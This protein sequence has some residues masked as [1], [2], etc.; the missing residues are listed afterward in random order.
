MR[1]YYEVFFPYTIL[2]EDVAEF[3]ENNKDLSIQNTGRN[4]E[5]IDLEVVKHINA[6]DDDH[7]IELAKKYIAEEDFT[8]EFWSLIK[9]DNKV[10]LTEEENELPDNISVCSQCDKHSD[11]KKT[12]I[13]S[14]DGDPFCSQECMEKFYCPKCGAE[15]ST[16]PEDITTDYFGACMKC[17]E[18]F[19]KF[20]LITKNV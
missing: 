8:I 15:I 3:L 7:A 16:K 13:W 12:T 2:R 9:G 19:Y 4:A 5:Y 20:E 11:D 18:D 10:I 14:I 6:I 17:D 1:K